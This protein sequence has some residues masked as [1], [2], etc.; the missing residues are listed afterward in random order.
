MAHNRLSHT[1][2]GWQQKSTVS[3]ID[4]SYLICNVYEVKRDN[5]ILLLIGICD[6]IS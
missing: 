3:N 1:V 5:Y 6:K 2:L 4:I